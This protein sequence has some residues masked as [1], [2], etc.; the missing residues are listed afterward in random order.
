MSQSEPLLVYTTWPDAESARAFAAEAVSAGLAAC[1]N[2]L[3]PMTAIYR[4][5]G[6]VEQAQEAPL[7]LK[8][9]RAAAEALRGRF[10][11]RHPYDTPA[12]VALPVDA[13]ASH[14]GYLAWLAAET[15]HAGRPGTG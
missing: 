14:G 4:W 13:A 8:T 2:L 5:Q 11:E 3:G 15:G 10:L 1:A 6:A 7:L 12:F 9:T